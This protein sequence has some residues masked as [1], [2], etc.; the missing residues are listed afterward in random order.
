MERAMK[1][2]KR[3]LA[4]RGKGQS[5][6]QQTLSKMRLLDGAIKL[7]P[8]PKFKKELFMTKQTSTHFALS[9]VVLGLM[10]STFP[11]LAQSKL[12]AGRRM[13]HPPL[14]ASQGT[15]QPNETVPPGSPTYTFTVL[16]FPGTFF[17]SVA[18]INSGAASSKI[19]IVGADVWGPVGYAASFAMSYNATKP[20]STETFRSVT[21]PKTIGQAANG[22]NDSGEIVG[23]YIVSGTTTDHGYL[24]S[25]GKFINIAVPFSGAAGESAF[26]IN[27]SGEIVGTWEDATTQHGFQLSGAT[28]TSFDY[29]SAVSTAAM[30]VNN[31]GEIVGAYTDLSGVT[32]GF[33][34][35]GG[36]YASYDP[37]G[38]TYTVATGI[39]DAGDIVGYYCLTS[40]C[41]AGNGWPSPQGFLLSGGTYTTITIPG[42]TATWAADINNNGLIVG[43]YADGVGGTNGSNGFLATP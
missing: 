6:S 9:L 43:D 38:S 1:N 37:P 23:Y 20:S 2:L 27:N 24:R 18:A 42:A 14:P 16:A 8:T 11:C 34:L 35:S 33:T 29:P 5:P 25:G 7:E 13:N 4:V 22:V 30:S 40:E 41:A 26:M 10:L 28:Y 36:T 15:M 21:K 19:E 32:H 17:T 12:A 3:Q 31:P 39:N